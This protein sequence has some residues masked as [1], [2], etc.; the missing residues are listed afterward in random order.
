[1]EEIRENFHLSMHGIRSIKPKVEGKNKYAWND[2]RKYLLGRSQ[3]N[4]FCLFIF[5]YRPI[6]QMKGTLP[7]HLM[8]YDVRTGFWALSIL[9]LRWR[10][11]SVRPLVVSPQSYATIARVVTLNT[12]DV[13]K[14]AVVNTKNVM[15]YE[16]GLW[17]QNRNK[18]VRK[19]DGQIFQTNWFNFSVR[20]IVSI[21]L[22]S[23]C[24]ITVMIS[25][26]IWITCWA[27]LITFHKA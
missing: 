22:I 7:F 13:P 2:N 15:K 20:L 25:V 10:L 9:P 11:H 4:S 8:L 18:T 17:K 14:G 26:I 5:G 21:E 16:C 3:T 1:M 23:A 6:V 12:R 19:L 24:I 27:K